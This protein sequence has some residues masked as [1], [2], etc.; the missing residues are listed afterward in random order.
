MRR[1]VSILYKNDNQNSKVELKK[2]HQWSPLL[3]LLFA[4]KV[5]EVLPLS[6]DSFDIFTLLFMLGLWIAGFII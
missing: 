3:S 5:T 1:S 4:V 2:N 6:G